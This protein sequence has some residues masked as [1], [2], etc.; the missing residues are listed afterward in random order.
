[1]GK[2]SAKYRTEARVP[3]TPTEISSLA[4]PFSPH[5]EN[6]PECYYV[7][8]LS[9]AYIGVLIHTESISI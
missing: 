1:M 5:E 2:N 6:L 8:A 3:P 7:P 9:R 4:Q